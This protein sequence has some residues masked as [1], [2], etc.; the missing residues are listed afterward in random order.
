MLHCVMPARCA[1]NSTHH[2]HRDNRKISEAAWPEQ[3]AMI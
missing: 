2:H 1:A 3:A